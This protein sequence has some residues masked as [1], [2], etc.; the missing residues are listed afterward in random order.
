MFQLI[1][2][3]INL[4]PYVWSYSVAM[5]DPGMVLNLG[6]RSLLVLFCAIV[7]GLYN[8]SKRVANYYWEAIVE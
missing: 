2:Y 4:I 3:N 6:Y 5:A 7:M 1:N 8:I